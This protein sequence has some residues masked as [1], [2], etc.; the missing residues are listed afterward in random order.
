MTNTNTTDRFFADD[1]PA[2]PAD[3]TAGTWGGVA[4]DFVCLI[5]GRPHAARAHHGMYLV[6]DLDSYARDGFTCGA[7]FANDEI[8]RL[9]NR[10]APK[11]PKTKRAID[12]TCPR[13][14]ARS[15]HA[16]RGERTPSASTLGGG[17]GG[18]ALLQRPHAERYAARR[19]TNNTPEARSLGFDAGNCAAAYGGESFDESAIESQSIGFA[20]GYM[21]GFF[22]SFETFEVPAEY[23]ALV[24][25]YRLTYRAEFGDDSTSN[26][27][28]ARPAPRI[29]LHFFCGDA[30]PCDGNVDADGFCCACGLAKSHEFEAVRS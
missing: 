24:A 18:P 7:H 16:C 8:V 9:P 29:A 10:P 3:A 13:C 27:R 6:V 22:S 2:L 21:L 23:R 11:A 14:N 17:W 5:G 28:P 19:A 26:A 12:F 4:A 20:T 15:G 1:L 30:T 25:A